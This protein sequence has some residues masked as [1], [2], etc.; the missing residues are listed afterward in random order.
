MRPWLRRLTGC[1]TIGRCRDCPATGATCC[2]PSE[3]RPT[4]VTRRTC[5]VGCA[6]TTR[7]ATGVG[8]AGGGGDWSRRSAT[9][10]AGR[11]SGWS[12]GSRRGVAGGCA[13]RGCGD[14]ASG[15][16]GSAGC[17]AWIGDLPAPP[18][19]LS[20]SNNKRGVGPPSLLALDRPQLGV[21]VDA[22]AATE[23]GGR[24][25]DGDASIFLALGVPGVAEGADE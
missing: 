10:I 14:G 19:V 9:S 6:S 22:T 2:F 16:S 5:G 1:G 7:P 8:P 4:P 18:G 23:G 21:R 15:L 3:G 17:L 20:S 11:R 25:S 13:P 12:G 24:A